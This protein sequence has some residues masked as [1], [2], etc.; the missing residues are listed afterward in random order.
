MNS[1][2]ESAEIWILD[3]VGKEFSEIFYLELREETCF[4]SELDGLGYSVIR[5]ITLKHCCAEPDHFNA[6]MASDAKLMR[7]R[8]LPR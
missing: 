1:N 6:V 3:H 8:I 4:V 7:L 5:L 2:A